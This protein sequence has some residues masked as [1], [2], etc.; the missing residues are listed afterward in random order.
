MTFFCVSRFEISKISNIFSTDI[1]VVVS[2]CVFV[3]ICMNSNSEKNDHSLRFARLMTSIKSIHLSAIDSKLQ[4]LIYY[5]YM[6][7]NDQ[8]RAQLE[9]ECASPLIW[10]L[11]LVC[12]LK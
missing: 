7:A 2:F 9:R 11:S 1:V 3:L 12:S 8:M 5:I 6:N 10:W 4:S